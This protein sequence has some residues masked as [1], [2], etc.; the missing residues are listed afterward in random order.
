MFCRQQPAPNQGEGH[1]RQ[2]AWEKLVATEHFSG[3]SLVMVDEC[4]VADVKLTF[5]N[6]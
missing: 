1:A 3:P 2:L 6:R 5:V 4:A